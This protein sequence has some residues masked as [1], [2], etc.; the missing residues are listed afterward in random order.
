M[1]NLFACIL[2][3]L[4]VAVAQSAPPDVSPAAGRQIVQD[5]LALYRK[6]FPGIV[7]MHASGGEHWEQEYSRITS[8]LGEAPDAL[9]Y[10]H[11]PEFTSDLMFVT[12]H[13]LAIML[14]HNVAS[15]TLFRA[16]R[17]GPLQGSMLCVITLDTNELLGDKLAATRYMLDLNEST[18]ARI[19]PARRLDLHD[20][21]LFAIDHE[22]YHCLESALIGGA[23]MTAKTLGGE[24][25]QYQRENSADAFALL[26]HRRQSER[27][28]SF[29]QNIMLTR[30]LWF[31]G[32]EPYYFTGKA[33]GK[34][35]D[36]PR[37][38][39]IKKSMKELVP[40]AAKVRSEACEDYES[41][42][43]GRAVALQAAAKL[44][45]KPEDFGPAWASLAKREVKP[46]RVNA[47]TSYY[48]GLYEHLFDDTPIK[49]SAN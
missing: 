20:Y 33:L 4:P 42:L 6:S 7:F 17:R 38:K 45:F 16:D 28:L 9:D 24:Y 43:D 48:M 49:F 44:G 25:N 10:E 12:L 30:A 47:T 26:M 31:L 29:T 41:F 13:R 3:M 27:S 18:L 14:Q 23:P 35:N 36:L 19:H 1:R 40:L 2:V 22:I 39:L 37:D 32:G 8:L 15:E 34:I 5:R 46:E 11:P 21:L